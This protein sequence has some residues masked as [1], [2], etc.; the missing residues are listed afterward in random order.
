MEPGSSQH[1]EDIAWLQRSNGEIPE[2][3]ATME[4]ALKLNPQSDLILREMGFTYTV[5]NRWDD[6]L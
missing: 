6:V 1:L 3:L 4:K 5:A 2:A